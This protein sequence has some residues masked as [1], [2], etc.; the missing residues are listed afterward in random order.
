MVGFFFLPCSPACF[1]HP[2]SPR[3]QHPWESCHW[4]SLG[5]RVGCAAL[6]IPMPGEGRGWEKQPPAPM[7]CSEALYELFLPTSREWGYSN[8]LLLGVSPEL[9]SSRNHAHPLLLGGGGEEDDE[10]SSRGACVAADGFSF[11]LFWGRSSVI[12]DSNLPSAAR[13]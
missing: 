6:F 12:I 8:A 13:V 10:G 2:T 5:I 3:A 7:A 9:W 11:P 4:L 1:I